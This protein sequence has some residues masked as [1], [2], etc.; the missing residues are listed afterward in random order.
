MRFTALLGVLFVLASCSN[1]NTP[2]TVVCDASKAGTGFHDKSLTFNLKSNKVTSKEILNAHGHESKKIFLDMTQ[3]KS[4]I[5]KF[6][7]EKLN[8]F[9]EMFDEKERSYVIRSIDEG[10]ITYAVSEEKDISVDIEFTLDRANLNLK[11]VLYNAYA[12]D[13]PDMDT[14]TVRYYDCKIPSV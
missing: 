4:A 8:E 13:Y 2:F 10:F 11:E 6:G 9:M 5:E 14:E 3:H 12:A 1:Q 7:E